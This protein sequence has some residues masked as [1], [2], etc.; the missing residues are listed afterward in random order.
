M[1]L[2]QCSLFAEFSP[3]ELSGLRAITHKTVL[4]AGSYAFHEKD[5]GESLL[6]LTVGTLHITKLSPTGDEEELAV[7]STGSYTGEMAFFGPGLRSASGK[8][9]ERVEII[10]VPYPELRAL[11]DAEPA[12]AAKFYKAVATGVVRRV[13]SMNENVAFLKAFLK[14]RD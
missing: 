3:A 5:P 14:A 4:E 11:L 8:A 6:I 2:S 7:L 12:V 9:L 1:D 13:H 10:A